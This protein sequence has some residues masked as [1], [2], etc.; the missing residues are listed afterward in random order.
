MLRSSDDVAAMPARHHACPTASDDCISV[1]RIRRDD[2]GFTLIEVIIVMVLL[3]IAM[4]AAL[5]TVNSVRRSSADSQYTAA[6]S[7]I[8]RGIGSYRLDNKGR[9]PRVENLQGGGRGFT[10]LARVRYVKAWPADPARSSNPLGIQRARTARP[11]TTG[12]PSTV[13][14]SGSGDAG[15]LAA[16]GHDGRLIFLRGITAGTPEAPVG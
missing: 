15:W 13:V 8:W 16:Y 10:N 4:F 2:V 6:A 12:S 1:Q 9:L 14:Y 7:T 3:G 5:T 11:A